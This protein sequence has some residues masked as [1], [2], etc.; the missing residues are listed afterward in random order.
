MWLSGFFGGFGPWRPPGGCLGPS[1]QGFSR[2]AIDSDT[3]RLRRP[4]PRFWAPRARTEVN[5]TDPD[6]QHRDRV[7]RSV[8]VLV[9]RPLSLPTHT[10]ETSGSG[11]GDGAGT[12]TSTLSSPVDTV[13]Y[14]STLGQ[15]R[16]GFREWLG[17]TPR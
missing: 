9:F 1:R 2:S 17:G 10:P 6:E 12:S 3:R 16:R 7:A 8:G 5:W 4:P 14:Y 13:N 15:Q 11:S